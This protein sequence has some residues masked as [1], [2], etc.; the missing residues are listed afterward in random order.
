MRFNGSIIVDMDAADTATLALVISGEGSD[1]VDIE[2]AADA[3]T[4]LSGMLVA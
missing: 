4:S 3:R 2:G 1:V